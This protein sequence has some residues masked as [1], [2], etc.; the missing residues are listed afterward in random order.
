MA[1]NAPDAIVFP[2]QVGG[3]HPD[4]APLRARPEVRAVAVWDLLFGSIDGEPGGLLFASHD[5][6]YLGD[7]GRPVVVDGRMYDPAAPDEV[8]VSEELAKRVPVGTTVDFRAFAP[9]QSDLSGDAPSGPAL[10]MKVVGVV[11]LVNQFLFTPSRP[12][13]RRDTAARYEGSVYLAENADVRLANGSADI[14]ALQRDVNE[15]LAPGTPVLD[16]HAVS[17]RV[18]TTLSVERTALFSGAVVALGRRVARC[19]GPDPLGRGGW[20]RRSCASG[21]RYGA[22][23]PCERSGSRDLVTVATAMVVAAVA[24]VFVSALFPVGL[25]RRIDVDVGVHAD[26]TV[27][28]PGVAAT[29]AVVLAAVVLVAWRATR[30]AVRSTAQRPSVLVAAV[31]RRAPLPVGI[32]TSMAF[33]RGRGRSSVP[34]LPALLGAIAGVLGVV[35]IL[36]IDNGIHD[37][38]AHP[39]RA[40]VTW[41]ATAE[42]ELSAYEPSG[43]RGEAVDQ[44][45]AAAP[46][47]SSAVVIDRQ[48]LDVDGVGVPTFSLRTPHGDPPVTLSIAKGNA[49]RA[50]GEAAIGPETARIL[51]VGIG[52]SVSFAL[53]NRVRLV[54]I[55]LFPSDVHAEF[56]E[57]LWVTPDQMELVSP[58]P[59]DGNDFEGDRYVALRFPDRVDVTV[60]T[61]RMGQELGPPVSDIAP[62]QV[63]VELE[64][65]RGARAAGAPRRFAAGRDRRGEPRAGH[66]GAPPTPRLRDLAGPR[67]QSPRR[68]PRAQLAGHRD[69]AGRAAH[70]HPDR[71]CCGSRVAGA[72]SRNRCRSRPYHRSR[73]LRCC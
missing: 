19:P 60:Q 58:S 13:C 55:G 50:V 2:S 69:R 35:A 52:D 71:C 47:G 12:S 61:G 48:V 44:I 38:L 57:G 22:A 14:P 66:V 33:E 62:A 70:R 17:R 15:L 36:T 24:A 37:S 51:G 34:V 42:V 16:L 49:P 31:R 11:R 59:V 67:T 68:P 41:D 64:N 29:G 7:V 53:G 9:D 27:L 18:D 23:R 3:Y 28:V 1:T 72:G 8:V 56:D 39:E 40:G 5:G 43:L 6:M 25:G 54:G 4:W 30:L 63:P 32:G 45:L 73:S 65:L 46:P 26:W 21:R 10:T 20:R